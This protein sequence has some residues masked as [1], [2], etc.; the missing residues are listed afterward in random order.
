MILKR[1]KNKIKNRLWHVAISEGKRR[2]DEKY[3]SEKR[4]SSQEAG[5]R[6][7][8]RLVHCIPA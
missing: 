5:R 3:G 7:K 1:G 2:W 8:V 4:E 6:K